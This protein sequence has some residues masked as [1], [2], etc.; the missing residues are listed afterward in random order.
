MKPIKQYW[1]ANVP[2][3][4]LV[5]VA[6]PSPFKTPWLPRISW[7]HCLSNTNS[8]HG[9][10]N[11]SGMP[12]VCVQFRQTDPSPYLCSMQR[13]LCS[14]FNLIYSKTFYF[15]D[16]LNR[17]KWHR[18]SAIIIKGLIEASLVSTY[19]VM[20]ELGP[21]WRFYCQNQTEWGIPGKESPPQMQLVM[22]DLG[23]L[24]TSLARIP[25][26]R[27]GTSHVRLMDFR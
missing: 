17:S 19:I 23:T 2:S 26:P 24:G 10:I 20:Q 3:T 13:I 27:N 5:H 12:Q 15:W 11:I 8:S 16:P 6:E 4:L 7:N 1:G 21:V 18:S 9:S 25:P 22:E 14:F